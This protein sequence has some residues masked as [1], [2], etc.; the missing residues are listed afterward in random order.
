MTKGRQ[1][2]FRFS[3]AQQRT[4]EMDKDDTNY[5]RPVTQAVE[6]SGAEMVIAALKDQGVTHIF[7]Y[8]GGAVLPIF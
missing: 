7:G 6:M 3:S 8:P 4:S 5:T 2:P 1:R